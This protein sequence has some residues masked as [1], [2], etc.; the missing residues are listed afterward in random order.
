V[1]TMQR[2]SA[3]QIEAD[4]NG[5]RTSL[6]DLQTQLA[7][8]TQ[9]LEM[10]GTSAQLVERIRGELSEIKADFSRLQHEVLREAEKQ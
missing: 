10:H 3:E 5:I 1:T 4:V 9:G 8:F 2:P 6:R 7:E